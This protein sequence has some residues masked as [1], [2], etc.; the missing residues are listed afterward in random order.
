MINKEMVKKRYA[1]RNV[2]WVFALLLL[3]G[4]HDQ[5]YGELTRIDII[6]KGKEKEHIQVDEELINIEKK[7]SQIEWVP[8]MKPEME[9]ELDAEAHFFFTEDKNEPET[10]ATYHIWFNGK[11]AEI[12]SN[13]KR[14]GFGRL[15]NG[16]DDLKKLLIGG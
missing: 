11:N 8:N 1:F 6:E 5:K 7:M 15:E 9:R 16:S 3:T 4:C 13:D 10:I 14:E 2:I 12:L